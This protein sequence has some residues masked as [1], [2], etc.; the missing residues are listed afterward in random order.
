MT[1]KDVCIIRAKLKR[2]YVYDAISRYGYDIQTPYTGNQMVPR[3]FRELFFRYNLPLKNVWYRKL[4]KSDYKCI[5]LFDPLITPD[6]VK[7]LH[8]H[9]PDSRI[10]M[11]Y[12]NRADKT[13]RPDSLPDYVEKWSYDEDDCVTYSMQ[14]MA[15]SYFMNYKRTPNKAPR[16][17][18]LYVG[19][20][21]RRAEYLLSLE[22]E[23]N[24]N[25]LKTYFHICADRKYLR[26]KRKYYKRLLD[27]DEYLELLV[28]SKAVLNIV[29]DG[30]KSITQRE[31]EAVF[32]GL[33]CITNNRG[34]KRFELYDKNMFF[35]LG[36]DDIAKVNEFL[37]SETP[38][39]DEGILKEFDFSHRIEQMIG[40]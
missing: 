18:L 14:W 38:K 10:V 4:R 12:E 16:Y 1:P 36:E 2:D 24:A 28:D 17:D 20:D 39:Y 27:Y 31:M 35:I 21:K 13:I 25:G 37:S 40:L 9:N 8:S 30:Q 15:P 7:W 23:L 32:D 22:K 33:K 19:R 5:V 6:Y 29:P 26:F 11:A 34:V 3:V